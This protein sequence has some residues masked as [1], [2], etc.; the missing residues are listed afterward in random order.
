MFQGILVSTGH[1]SCD[2]IWKILGHS[3]RCPDAHKGLTMLTAVPPSTREFLL[4][5]ALSS[6]EVGGKS[7]LASWFSSL[8]FPI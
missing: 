8:E 2:Q 3:P 5:T 6:R 4:P 7:A 1:F